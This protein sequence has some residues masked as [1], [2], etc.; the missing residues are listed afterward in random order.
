MKI[1]LND[2]WSSANRISAVI[3]LIFAADIRATS[4]WWPTVCYGHS[5]I[6]LTLF[7]TCFKKADNKKSI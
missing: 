6:T 2:S 5:S 1:E 3:Q 7:I 4:F